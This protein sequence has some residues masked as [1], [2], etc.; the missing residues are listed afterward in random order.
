MGSVQ[1]WT[2]AHVCRGTALLTATQHAAGM[3]AQRP[4]CHVLMCVVVVSG[5]WF[6]F[7]SHLPALLRKNN[8]ARLASD[9]RVSELDSLLQM[10]GRTPVQLMVQSALEQ[11]RLGGAFVP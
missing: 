3:P 2:S 7:Y 5:F 10:R 11:T 8:A 9:S 4:H 1:G 6:Y